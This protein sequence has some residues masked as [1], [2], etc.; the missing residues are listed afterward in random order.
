M[1]KLQG[2]DQLTE[3]EVKAYLKDRQKKDNHN[4]IERRRRFNINDRIKELGAM[5]PRGHDPEFR[6]N[7]GSILKATVDYIKKLEAEKEKF[8]KGEAR[9]KDNAKNYEKLCK[10]LYLRIQELEK[11]AS[12]QGWAI[13]PSQA[14]RDSGAGDSILEAMLSSFNEGGIKGHDAQTTLQPPRVSHNQNG[15]ATTVIKQSPSQS[16]SSTPIVTL[17]PAEYQGYSASPRQDGRISAPN[18]LSGSQLPNFYGASQLPAGGQAFPQQPQQHQPGQAPVPQEINVQNQNTFPVIQLAQDGNATIT[19]V[20]C[21]PNAN[22][23]NGGDYFNGVVLKQE[24]DDPSAAQTMEYGVDCSN[25]ATFVQGNDAFMVDDV[26]QMFSQ[27]N[28]DE[29]V[30]EALD[31]L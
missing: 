26:N 9:E 2:G 8:R 3:D 14:S 19:F 31:L 11:L 5:L 28:I 10:N 20:Q 30:R 27:Q 22:G 15:G 1:A 23:A 18:S 25:F 17:S 6:A 4:Q 24:P 12:D 16:I 21:D 29:T 7:K 13:P